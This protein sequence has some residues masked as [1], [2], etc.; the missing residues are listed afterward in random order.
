MTSGFLN[1]SAFT[2]HGFRGDIQLSA[3]LSDL[4]NERFGGAVGM[5]QLLNLPTLN[6]GNE[7]SAGVPSK[8]G[9]SVSSIFRL[10][11][12]VLFEKDYVSGE[13]FHSPVL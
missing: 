5:Y 13:F 10:E 11:V 2:P 9:V 1:K 4:V 6:I 3:S 7:V 12:F 8:G